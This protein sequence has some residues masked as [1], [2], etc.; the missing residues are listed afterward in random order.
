MNSLRNNLL[1]QMNMELRIHWLNPLL[2][3]C[4]NYY[5]RTHGEQ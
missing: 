1:G 3:K 2:D 4:R 5:T